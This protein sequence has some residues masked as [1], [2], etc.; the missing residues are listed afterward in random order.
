MDETLTY[1]NGMYTY[2]N[3]HIYVN[4][5]RDS[6]A[7]YIR[8]IG[9]G[10][11]NSVTTP[12]FPGNNDSLCKY[13]WSGSAKADNSNDGERTGISQ[14]TLMADHQM[15]IMLYSLHMVP[16]GLMGTKK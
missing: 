7:L 10:L 1:E 5:E 16:G 12:K 3:S 6:G 4:A 9:D 2:Q 11:G 15:I 13:H 8:K 14:I